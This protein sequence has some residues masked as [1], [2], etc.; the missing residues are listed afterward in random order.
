MRYISIWDYMD[1]KYPIQIFIGGR[2]TGK[3]FSGF[4]GLLE[5][6][7]PFVFMRRTDAEI[8]LMLDDKNGE[9]ANPFTPIND[10]LGYNVGITKI[11]KKLNGVYNREYVEGIPQPIG[12]PIGYALGMSTIAGMRGFD[13]SRCMYVF[14]DEFIREAHVKRMKNEGA[15]LLN[16][17]ETIARNRELEGQEPLYMFVCSNSTDIY[18]DVFVELGLVYEIELASRKGKSDIYFPDRDLAVHLLEASEEFIEAKS[19]STIMKLTRG[20][21]FEESAL[22][23]KFA[24]NDFSLIKP[25]SLNGFRPLCT[26][27]KAYI[28]AKKGDSLVYVSYSP[29]QCPRYNIDNKQDVMRFYNE[30]GRRLKNIF[31]KSRITFESYELKR[32][33]LDLII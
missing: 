5:R 22:Y 3:T 2:G 33:I 20:T 9:G 14:Y 17:Y 30:Y 18:N 16:A 27:G 19:Q 13:F 1:P 32:L 11:R 15:A 12:A 31:T 29:A 8:D 25:L 28:Y 24:Y 6:K 23:N 21:K 26:I 4:A 10:K 7:Q